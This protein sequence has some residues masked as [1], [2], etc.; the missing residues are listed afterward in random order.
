MIS[1]YKDDFNNTKLKQRFIVVVLA[2]NYSKLRFFIKHSS[3][4]FWFFISEYY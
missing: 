4:G 2:L 3:T 1:I